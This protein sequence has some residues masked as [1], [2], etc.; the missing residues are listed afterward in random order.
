MVQNEVVEC[1]VVETT[2]ESRVD[3]GK[4]VKVD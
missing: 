3:A 1:G 2:G 4:E